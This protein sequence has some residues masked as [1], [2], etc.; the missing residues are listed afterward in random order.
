MHIGHGNA[1]PE[2]VSEL[3][4][5]RDRRVAPATAP[6]AGLYL[7]HVQYPSVFGLP[8]DSDIMRCPAGCPAD[9]MDP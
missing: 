3:L 7:W 5:G 6:A 4:A 2:W 1:R 9:L 8:D